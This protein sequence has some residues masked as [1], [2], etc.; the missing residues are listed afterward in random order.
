M[1]DAALNTAAFKVGGVAQVVK[2]LPRY[3]TISV[4]SK[5]NSGKTVLVSEIISTLLREKKVDVCLVMSGS[6]R[7]NTD[8]SFL[9]KRLVMPFNA[10]YLEAVWDSQAAKPAAKRQHVLI[11]LDDA[12][13]TPEA[14]RATI[15][16]RYFS[17]GR[18]ISTSFI[19]ISQHTAVLLSPII[20]ANSDVILWSKLNRAQLEELWGSTTNIS[21]KDFIRVSEAH[22][23]VRH[24][25]ML[26]DN[27]VGSADPGEFLAVVKAK[28]PEEK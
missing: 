15:I 4:A 6:A 18:H 25:F 14:I 21:R 3:F 10:A 26:L 8:Y 9:P 12:L 24:Q 28:P 22:G 20:K 19:V 1:D 16:T 11:V 23:G 17:L 13:A 7:L 2:R 5:R 27:F